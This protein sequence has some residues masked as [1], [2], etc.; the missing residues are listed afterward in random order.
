[1][2]KVCKLG[3]EF[4]LIISEYSVGLGVVPH[5]DR[6]SE[7]CLFMKISPMPGSKIGK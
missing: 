3:I 4:H 6:Y 7:N 5:V 2:E 1:L